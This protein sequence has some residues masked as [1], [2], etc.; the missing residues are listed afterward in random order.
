MNR[1]ASR[2]T[3]PV[4]GG[5]FPPAIES[6]RK[7]PLKYFADHAVYWKQEIPEKEMA[8]MIQNLDGRLNYYTA[9]PYTVNGAYVIEGSLALMSQQEWTEEFM[10][11]VYSFLGVCWQNLYYVMI[12]QQLLLEASPKVESDS[13][14]HFI[15]ERLLLRIQYGFGA[16]DDS[17]PLDMSPWNLYIKHAQYIRRIREG[18]ASIATYLL[19][20][21][22]ENRPQFLAK[23]FFYALSNGFLAQVRHL[24]RDLFD[25]PRFEWNDI[26]IPAGNTALWQLVEQENVE[27]F[28]REYLQT[29]FELP[30]DTDDD[31]NHDVRRILD[32]IG[33]TCFT[34][35]ISDVVYLDDVTNVQ[36]LDQGTF[37]QLQ[38]FR[39]RERT[40][41]HEIFRD[42]TLMRWILYIVQAIQIGL[43]VIYQPVH[44]RLP[45]GIDDEAD[46]DNPSSMTTKRSRTRENEEYNPHDNDENMMDVNNE[47]E[48]RN[49]ELV[50]SSSSFAR[51]Q[52]ARTS[53]Y[54]TVRISP[55]IEAPIS[56]GSVFN[57]VQQYKAHGRTI[58]QIDV[59][60]DSARY[61][62]ID[63]QGSSQN[64]LDAIDGYAVIKGL[65]AAEV[66][67]QLGQIRTMCKNQGFRDRYFELF[68]LHI[69]WSR[70]ESPFDE[71][72][73][74]C[75]DKYLKTSKRAS[76]QTQEGAQPLG[77]ISIGNLDGKGVLIL[78]KKL[79]KCIANAKNVPVARR[80]AYVYY[81][82]STPYALG[83]PFY[84]PAIYPVDELLQ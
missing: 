22:S 24:V 56:R 55:Q 47:T 36:E 3:Q 16:I 80:V 39:Q 48:E 23:S 34:R 76:V 17:A 37:D 65:S 63:F 69:N 67:T 29:S 31:V 35:E 15:L 8:A 9:F 70:T 58:R 10:N 78:L 30:P 46:D 13:R 25:Q 75:I 49:A 57:A 59:V 45:D 20:L 19:G 5:V 81:D 44:D 77:K 68:S 53:L 66:A 62:E 18:I 21:S 4:S 82:R 27:P 74:T 41:N 38:F 14:S 54:E 2:T 73:A 33:R 42:R 43:N 26:A 6:N 52:R 28:L 40:V 72:V 61:I 7:H 50:P 1:R 84:V 79:E 32:E 71:Q 51:S 83:E 60:N 64:F 12:I 11:R